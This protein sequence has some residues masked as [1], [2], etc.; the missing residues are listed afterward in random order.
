VTEPGPPPPWVA[1]DASVPGPAP[2]APSS[3]AGPGVP[4]P[5][6]A[7]RPG[8]TRRHPAPEGPGPPVPLRR[9]APSDLLDGAFAVL[10]ASPANVLAVAALFVV[11]VQLVAAWLQ[12][13][14]L[15]AL[16]LFDVLAGDEAA[17]EAVEEDDLGATAAGLLGLM[18]MSIS[19]PFVCAATTAL[20]LAR[21][22]GH[23][24][25][26]GELVGIVVRKAPILLVAWVLVHIAQV[27]GL[28]LCGVGALAAMT[29]FLVTAPA[30]VA[31][32][33]GPV[34]AMRRSA[35]LAR[36]RFWPTLG[37]ALLTGLVA[38][39]FDQALSSAPV[40][41]AVVVGTEGAGWLL[42]GAG[43]VMSSIV[44]TPVVAAA[45]TLY[46]LDLRVRTEGLD[47]ELEAAAVLEPAP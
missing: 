3:P 32:D 28:F 35:R 17:I 23:D 27:F 47:L 43:G 5:P 10:K 24:P 8:S 38:S 16:N 46:Y 44:T 20:V 29:L 39:L 12:R 22:R 9:L 25:S 4:E 6:L 34:A 13:D 42:L 26:L 41:L 33:L 7:R 15:A 19:L 18:G 1:P 14:A 37:V 2:A 21:H 11:P 31:E 36:R 30:V 40:L 45:T